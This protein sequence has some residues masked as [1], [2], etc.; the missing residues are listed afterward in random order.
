MWDKDGTL[1]DNF[2]VWIRRERSLIEFLCTDLEI[3]GNLRSDAVESGLAAIG[4]RD[5]KVDPHGELAGGTEAS[6]CDA[7]SGA[8]SDFGQV[9]EPEEFRRLVN[10]RLH[11]I[12]ARDTETPPPA[13]RCSRSPNGSPYP[14][15]APG[16]GHV[17]QQKIS[18][19]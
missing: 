12:L 3:A 11:E 18:P 5:G 4:I 7:I 2:S 14:R 15:T 6:I 1:L 9:P 16:P 10:G 17:G 19:R 13:P 8:L